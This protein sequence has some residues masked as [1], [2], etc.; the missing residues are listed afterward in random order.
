[1]HI[2]I[3]KKYLTYNQYKVKCAVGKRGIGLKKKEGD[4]ITPIGEYKIKY[5]LYRSDRIKKIQSKL[6]KMP[7]SLFKHGYSSCIFFKMFEI[8]NSCLLKYHW[9]SSKSAPVNISAASP[10]GG[11]VETLLTT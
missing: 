3:N 10:C 7:T 5:I 2:L 4:S 1:M 9:F 11:S 8:I 6:K